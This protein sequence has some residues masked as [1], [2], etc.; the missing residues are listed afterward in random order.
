MSVSVSV[1]GSV[2]TPLMTYATVG[3]REHLIGQCPNEPSSWIFVF[4]FPG[5]HCCDFAESNKNAFQWDAYRIL[6]WLPLDVS[7]GVGQIPPGCSPRCR[8]PPIERPP[9]MNTDPP[10]GRHP[11]VGRHLPGCRTPCP[12]PVDRMTDRRFWKHNLPLQS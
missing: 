7:M 8:S 10:V 5:F 3:H 6:Q 1:S 9:P 2:N 11:T 12:S 4:A